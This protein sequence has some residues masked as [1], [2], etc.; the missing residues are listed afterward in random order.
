MYTSDNAGIINEETE[1]AAVFCLSE[2]NRSKGGG[3][4]RKKPPEKTVFICKVYYPFWIG[5]FG[6]QNII[7]DGLN[8][9]SHIIG[10]PAYP[11]SE[12][13]KSNLRERSS[14]RQIFSTF[15]H[16]NSG[17]FQQTSEDKTLHIE[18][19]LTNPDFD[20]IFLDYSKE[21]NSESQIL[22]SVMISAALK[23]Q[24]VSKK[25]MELQAAQ[26][27]FRFELADLKDTIKQINV[28]T[29][30]FVS[31][32]RDEIT[33]IDNKYSGKIQRVTSNFEEQKAQ[34][35]K[36]YSENVT[37]I[38][39]KFEKE[40]LEH[41]KEGIGLKNELD[42]TK[43]EIDQVDIDIKNAQIS[44]DEETEQKFKTKR[45]ELKEKI[46]NF[47]FK[48]KVIK[49]K[50]QRLEE[51]KKEQ[52]FQL[53]QDNESKIANASKEV[54]ETITAR[55][56]EKKF[57]QD[58]MEKLEE[59]ASKITSDIDHLTR[60]VEKTINAFDVFGIKGENQ[61]LLLVY[62]PFY[63]ISY[64][65]QS[66]KR[67]NYIAPSKV[68]TLDISVKLKALGRKKITQLLESRSQE[69]SFILNKFM[70]LLDQDVAF[71]HEISDACEKQNILKS[72]D[73]RK[74][75]LSGL[76]ILKT[77]GWISDEEIADFSQ[78]LM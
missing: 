18:G 7:F 3:F 52:L 59:Y 22:G 43:Q 27:K 55:D 37:E 24:E 41:N 73:D 32:L 69:I 12:T 45:N 29:Q 76:G 53:R 23:E 71:R 48:I 14:T 56:A 61:P 63:L 26:N 8:L 72:A 11:S 35:N 66:D 36:V 19:L 16:N 62:M 10:Y 68:N 44:K 46:P 74:K 70:Q 51:D 4:L 60:L 54:T 58:E 9:W 13:F 31:A 57:C 42:V 34:L 49:E 28:K 78:S 15:L 67:F 65:V 50:I 39:E 6:D 77:D 1:K 25:I 17:Y 30:E 64:M 33:A 47:D 5:S 38:S 75:I 21:S 20:K 40:T 2:I